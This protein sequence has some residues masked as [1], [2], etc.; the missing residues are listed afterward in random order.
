MGNLTTLP[1]CKKCERLQPFPLKTSL[2]LQ[3]ERTPPTTASSL[4]D[5][6][7]NFVRFGYSEF[8]KERNLDIQEV[9]EFVVPPIG[10][11]YQ[12]LISNH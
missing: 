3:K 2:G 4:G 9:Y 8:V 10:K 1:R 12:S 5:V 7:V 6:G 11:G